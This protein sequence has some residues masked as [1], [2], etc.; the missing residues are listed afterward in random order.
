M[1]GKRLPSNYASKLSDGGVRMPLSALVLDIW[2]EDSLKSPLV[3]ETGDGDG[4]MMP[5]ERGAVPMPWLETSGALVPMW[6]FSDGGAAFEADPR[7]ALARVL[8]RFST[9]GWQGSPLPRWSF[10]WLMTA[11]VKC[12]PRSTR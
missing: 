3:F 9:R 7:H 8:D 1:R 4:Y 2:G 5:T 6:M 12:G 10:I 11:T